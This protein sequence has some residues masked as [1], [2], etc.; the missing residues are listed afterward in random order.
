M[1]FKSVRPGQPLLLLYRQF[2][3]RLAEVKDSGHKVLIDTQGPIMAGGGE[4]KKAIFSLL[5]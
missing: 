2:G 3:I 1:L 4:G 5:T